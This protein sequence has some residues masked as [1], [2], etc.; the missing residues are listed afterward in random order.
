MLRQLQVC[1]ARGTLLSTTACEN[2]FHQQ[3]FRERKIMTKSLEWEFPLPRTHTGILL[4]NAVMGASIWGGGATLC[5]TLSR[6]DFRDH[7]GGG[8]WTEQMR[9]ESIRELLEQKNEEALRK[10][11]EENSPG[12][13]EPDQPSALPVGRLEIRLEEGAELRRAT[14]VAARGALRIAFTDPRGNPATIDC[15]MDR[16]MPVLGLAMPSS[17]THDVVRI[18]AWE[19]V[20]DYL[21]SISFKAPDMFTDDS[22]AGWIQT[23]PADA[24][25][26]VGYRDLGTEVWVALEYGDDP[27]AARDR[28][29]ASIDT[30]ASAG[31]AGLARRSAAWWEAFWRRV[32]SIDIPNETLST[33]YYYGMFKFGGL[34]DPA[35]VPAT[36]QGPW[37]EEFR[38]PP[39]SS[40]YHFNIN[41]QM[42]YWPAYQGNCLEH[43]RPLFDMVWSWRDTLR[44]NARMFIGIDD[45]YLL[46]HA[47][48]DRCRIMGGFWSGTVDHACTAWVGKMM[49]DYWLYGGDTQFLRDTVYPFLVGALN[50][51][52]A[53]LEQRG[54]A[55]VLPLSVSPEYRANQIDAWG[56]NASFQLAALH[57]LL[58][59]LRNSARV[60]RLEP[61]PAWSDIQERLPRACVESPDGAPKIML[62]EG[63]DLEESHR[64]HSHIAGWHPFDVLDSRDPWWRDVL[65]ET[66]RWWHVKG[67]GLWSG[68]CIPW[69]AMI[70]ARAGSPDMTEAML[71][72]MDRLY[73]NEGRGTLHDPNIFEM[74]LGGSGPD[75]MLGDSRSVADAPMQMDAGMAATAATLD[76]MVQVRRGVHYLFQGAPARWRHVRFERVLTEGAFL[77]GAARNR[78]AVAA[79]TMTANRDGRLLLANPW[80]DRQRRRL[81]CT[82][83]ESVDLAADIV[84]VSLKKGQTATL[85]LERDGQ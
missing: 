43:L 54:D 28:S 21:S 71:E 48:D 9:Y 45:G 77:V 68:W 40:D 14:L 4:G 24:P 35:G 85:T 3:R 27:D 2:Y 6:A 11:F 51:Y 61:D 58:E 7:R 53:M 12:A 65:R 29:A 72:Y 79:V 36:L 57:W 66:Y 37:I 52:R 50:V 22:L 42:C 5:L 55:Y 67:M 32:P 25:L 1:G 82:G 75:V 80:T 19:Y 49:Y 83:A 38:M 70:H 44:E 64:H 26:C 8:Q 81:R 60:L 78:G 62:W 20:G 34:T 33:L 73:T 41:V 18:S 10:L 30:A 59:A 47:V 84:E 69:A 63:C 56:A 46:P 76:A 17:G 74:N 13:G 31:F 16:G 23:R 39:W 15:I